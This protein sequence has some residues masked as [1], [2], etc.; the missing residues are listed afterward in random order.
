MSGSSGAVPRLARIGHELRTPLNT[1]MTLSQLLLDGSI[2]RLE[3]DQRRYVEVIQRNGETVLRLLDDFIDMFRLESGHLSLAPMAFD[4]RDAVTRAVAAIRPVVEARGLELR[5][6]SSPSSRASRASRA[7]P[8]VIAD[9]DRVGQVL[10][11]LLA[12]AIKFTDAGRVTVST[13]LV[14]DWV[15]VHVD[16]TGVG[17]PPADIPR[18]FEEFFQGR[19]PR[20]RGGHRGGSGL[21]LAIAKGLATAMGGDLTVSSTLG[22]G[23]RFTLTL[24]RERRA[25]L[26][27]PRSPRTTSMSTSGSTSTTG[28]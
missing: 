23:S 27:T 3:R 1:V 22:R 19:A 4:V 6:V 20:Q 15:A 7:L 11:N 13:E 18:L 24:P 16:D 28:G 14:A 10:T 25:R 12:N 8:R 2:G 9:P 17:I 5:V 26:A 21:G